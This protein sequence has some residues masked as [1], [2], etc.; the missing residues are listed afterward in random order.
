MAL[1]H[2][3]KPVTDLLVLQGSYDGMDLSDLDH[4]DAAM[5]RA[6]LTIPNGA[7]AHGAVNLAGM[8][9]AFKDAELK[10]LEEEVCLPPTALTLTHSS[11][12]L[13]A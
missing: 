2:M 3:A 9:K 6:S 5:V 1:Q 10:R 4:Q 12:T 13:Y 8:S 11:L 7:A